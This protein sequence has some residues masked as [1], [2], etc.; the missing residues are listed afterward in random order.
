MENFNL[1]EMSLQEMSIEEMQSVEGGN[2]IS[3]ALRAVADFI[4]A[5]LGY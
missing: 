4:E 5:I 1:Q 3:D 2:R